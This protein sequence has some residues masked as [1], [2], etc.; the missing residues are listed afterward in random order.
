MSGINRDI[1]SKKG[2]VGFSMDDY[3]GN[4]FKTDFTPR[5]LQQN[6]KDL[7]ENLENPW[8]SESHTAQ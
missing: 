7:V 5:R 6:R 8:D 3:S 1:E 2:N 4:K